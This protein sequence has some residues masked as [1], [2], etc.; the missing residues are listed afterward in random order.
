MT[1]LDDLVSLEMAAT[2]A[3]WE[4]RKVDDLI[5]SQCGKCGHTRTTPW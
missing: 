2:P 4:H 3:P 5:V 1:K